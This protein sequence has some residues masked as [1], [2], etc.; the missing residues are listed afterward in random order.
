MRAPKARISARWAGWRAGI[1]AVTAL[2]AL[3]A[4]MVGASGASGGSD[5]LKAKRG[6]GLI[7]V[8]SNLYGGRVPYVRPDGKVVDLKVKRKALN[9]ALRKK[10]LRRAGI[11]C[12][13]HPATIGEE[14]VWYALDDTLGGFY[15][16]R[17]TLRARRDNVEVW[18]ASP[19]ARALPGGT[20][21]GLDFL[22]G[23]CRNGVRTTITDAQVNYLVVS[24]FDDNMYPKESAAFSVPPDRDGSRLHA[25]SAGAPLQGFTADPR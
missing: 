24:E 17:F 6:G 13:N 9:K 18:V 8:G 4:L 12:M 14:R 15:R 3:G 19:V 16:K 22:A 21:T 25:G 11:S 5:A 10:L 23:D 1:V 7:D 20:A 2:V